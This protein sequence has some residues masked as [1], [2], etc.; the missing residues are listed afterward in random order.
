[1]SRINLPTMGDTYDGRQMRQLVRQIEDNLR[2]LDQGVFGQFTITNYV[3]RTTLDGTSGTLS[4]VRE[5]L[6]SVITEMTGA[7]R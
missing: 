2:R 7:K 1:M 4:E 6:A 5:V 3:E